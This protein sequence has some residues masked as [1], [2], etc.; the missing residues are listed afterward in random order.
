MHFEDE[1][2][3]FSDTSELFQVTSE[4]TE[5][6]YEDAYSAFTESIEDTPA[7]GTSHPNLAAPALDGMWST[8]DAAM[9]AINVH[10]ERE[11][12]GVIVQRTTKK[13]GAIEKADL[14]CI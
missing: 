12:Y 13:G 11:G 10:A 1:F 6:L 2:E 7:L 8:R 4:D 9:K 14:A 3:G 5:S